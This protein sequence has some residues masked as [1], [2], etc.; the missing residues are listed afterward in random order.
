MTTAKRSADIEHKASNFGVMAW[1]S[2]NPSLSSTSAAWFGTPL[3]VERIGV[4]PSSGDI[5]RPV[6]NPFALL[7]HLK[8]L[9]AHQAL[10]MD[11]RD[12][13][14]VILNDWRFRVRVRYSDPA[15]VINVETRRDPDLMP[16]KTAELLSHLEHFER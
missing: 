8:S 4:F 1:L 5:H 2:K 11:D 10:D 6:S 15:I 7:D 3:L 13:L 12:G 16:V 9:Y 14:K